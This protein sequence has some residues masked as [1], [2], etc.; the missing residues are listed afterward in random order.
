MHKRYRLQFT[1]PL[2][3][4][5][6]GFGLESADAYIHSD[7]LFSA[8]AAMAVD[9]LGESTA[10]AHFLEVEA[11]AI[12]LSS[13]FP[14]R[15]EVCFFPKP[16]SLQTEWD[17]K[18]E[19][20]MDFQKAWRS[21]K[22]LSENRL[23]PALEDGK[24][25]LKKEDFKDRF[26]KNCLSHEKLDEFY[27][28]VELPRVVL[29]RVTNAATIFHFA[30]VTFEEKSGLFFLAKF[31]NEKAQQAFETALRALGDEGL[32]GE[33]SSGKGLFVIE[34]ISDFEMPEIEKPE[35]FLNLSLFIPKDEEI[36]KIDFAESWYKLLNRR[37]WVSRHTVR[38]KT[39]RTLTEGSVLRT[40][41]TGYMPEG[42][43]EKMFTASQFS[44]HHDVYRSWLAMALPIHILSSE[45][46]QTAES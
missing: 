13:A 3:I 26:A 27:E 10:K 2:H 4:S 38:R 30:Q 24:I 36:D 1:S 45:Q 32:G 17:W 18:E 25:F 19:E 11:P 40:H 21:V 43:L 20:G 42:E 33:R 16:L 37:G 31:K 14:W 29:D 34:S 28:N 22:F 23:R 6:G 8:V 46:K 5:S 9:L 15:G 12:A 41:E 39:R 35:G 44:L 7:T